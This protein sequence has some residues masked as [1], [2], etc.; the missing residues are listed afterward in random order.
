MPG[1]TVA[2]YAAYERQMTLSK[3]ASAQAAL[4]HPQNQHALKQTMM[5]MGAVGT[6]QPIYDTRFQNVAAAHQLM[7]YQ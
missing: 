6:S 7:Y 4:M 5:G 1:F 2:D 3:M